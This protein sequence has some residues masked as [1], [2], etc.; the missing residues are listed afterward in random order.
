MIDVL[1]QNRDRALRYEQT[2]NVLNFDNKLKGL[3]HRENYPKEKP[4]YFRPGK[5]TL[6]DYNI[7]S[8]I[9][10]QE[11]H[12]QAP[13]KR[14]PPDPVVRLIFTLN[15]LQKPEKKFVSKAPAREYNV[16]TNKY[17]QMN[18][19]KVQTND[20]VMKTEAAKKY[21][22]THDYDFMTGCFYDQ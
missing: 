15:F 8:N 9:S 14:P 4:W 12:F 19:L 11:H 20:E 3:E 5:D 21:W 6:V 17:L 18:D 10:M 7:I 1:A 22:K 2:Y 16:V 13:E